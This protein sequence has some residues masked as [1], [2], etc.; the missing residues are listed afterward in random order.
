MA[1]K[2]YRAA[3]E[4]YECIFEQ[5]AQLKAQEMDRLQELNGEMVVS[6]F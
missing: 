3:V 6:V 4:R 2:K 5:L 1:D